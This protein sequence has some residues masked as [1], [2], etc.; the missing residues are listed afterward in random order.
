MKTTAFSDVLPYES[1]TIEQ[2]GHRMRF[3]DEG[4]QDG[5]VILMVHGNPTWSFYYHH[6]IPALSQSH[7]LIIPDHMGCGRS[8]KPQDYPYTLAQHVSNL[9]RLV[10]HLGLQDITMM[11][12]DW[13]GAIGMG[14]AVRHPKKFKRFIVLNTS[15]FYVH[16]LPWNIRMCRIPLWG[17]LVVRGMNGFSQVATFAGVR[18]KIGQLDRKGL[19]AP[20]NNWQNRIAVL[21]FVQDIPREESHPTRKTINEIDAGLKQLQDK[22]MLICWG[23]C[24]FVF[25]TRDFLSG[26]QQRFPEAEVH[27][28]SDAGHYVAMDAHEDILAL[29][30]D[31]LERTD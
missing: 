26:W 14:V 31:F 6:L 27:V 28:F 30:Q 19:L 15:A 11:V 1:K 2:D 23:D 17:D 8:D 22:P 16:K 5:P 9:E 4:S 25:T 3:L 24:D 20:Y 18:R 12:H 10:E 29:T 7:R 13:G 21:R